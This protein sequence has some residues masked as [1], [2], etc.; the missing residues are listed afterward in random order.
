MKVANI[1]EIKNYLFTPGLRKEK[2]VT[3][4]R[5]IEPHMHEISHTDKAVASS[6]TESAL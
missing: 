1:I 6:S 2:K 4:S 3:C 5:R